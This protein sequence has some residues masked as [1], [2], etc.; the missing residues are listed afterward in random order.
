MA[1]SKPLPLTVKGNV[2]VPKMQS[3][4][5]IFNHGHL[6]LDLFLEY[7]LVNIM[8]CPPYSVFIHL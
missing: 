7:Q 8:P 1:F 6:L 2:S 4:L 3:H 5:S